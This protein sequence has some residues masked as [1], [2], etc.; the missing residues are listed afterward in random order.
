MKADERHDTPKTDKFAE[1]TLAYGE[2]AQVRVH[3][4]DSFMLPSLVGR[5]LGGRYE[6]LE[7]LGEG[8]MSAVYRCLHRSLNQI[9][10]V[11]VLH[12]DRVS[13]RRNLQRFEQE[14]KATFALNHPNLI[15]LLDYSVNEEELP[16]IVMEYV[17]GRTLAD[18]LI[19]DGRL[20]PKDFVS[21][22]SQICEG[23]AYAH[24]K[25][26][27]HRDLKPS[28]IM[29]N[30]NQDGTFDVKI[31]DFG[32]A[33]LT[34]GHDQQLTRTGDVFGS[35]LYM[36]PEQC[37]GLEPDHRS[38]LYSMGCAM[39]EALTGDPPF[40][41]DNAM[42]TMFMHTE[43]TVPPPK[44]KYANDSTVKSL[45]DITLCLLNKSPGDRIQTAQDVRDLLLA[46]Q[47]SQ[48]ITLPATKS[49]KSKNRRNR[50]LAGA[51]V[52]LG[53][54]FAGAGA[55]IFV[56]ES[57][58][59]KVVPESTP[60]NSAVIATAVTKS[61]PKSTS[62]ESEHPKDKTSPLDFSNQEGLNMVQYLDVLTATTED[63]IKLCQEQK[64]KSARLTLAHALE[65]A[66]DLQLKDDDSHVRP[67]LLNYCL[68][69]YFDDHT[70]N[71]DELDASFDRLQRVLPT[72]TPPFDK[73]NIYGWHGIVC[74]DMNQ[75]N[76]AV[77]LLNEAVQFQV[78]DGRHPE[79][80]AYFLIW[81]AHTEAKRKNYSE[82][83]RLYDLEE[84]AASKYVTQLIDGLKFKADDLR[85]AGM[86]AEADKTALRA[87]EVARKAKLD[88]NNPHYQSVLQYLRTYKLADKI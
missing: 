11:K 62:L 79:S 72:H 52:C 5:V 63:G 6:V 2:A 24:S 36:S 15:R 76:K 45:I 34:H 64:F 13:N 70:Q 19:E 78:K 71:P 75:L 12:I 1:A 41:G 23:L 67:I 51:A 73:G 7:L 40:R 83:W 68:A 53:L 48:P 49:A 29:L 87:A 22:F 42:Q 58:P 33:K 66:S 32:I 37:K 80:A 56:H 26:I 59:P 82:A 10:A 4:S 46:S 55:A 18:V 43:Q 81:Q 28:N 20:R 3:E 60:A 35:P 50:Y 9:V 85:A 54:L 74:S 21:I 86:I 25:N 27:I 61:G 57:M 65:L 17:P 88:A 8:G 69:R 38:D 14:A 77:D 84:K 31:V 39:Y 44:V 16:Y 47:R 30:A